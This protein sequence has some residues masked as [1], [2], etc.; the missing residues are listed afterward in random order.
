MHLSKQL[1]DWQVQVLLVGL[2]NKDKP[3]YSGHNVLLCNPP[4]PPHWNI[5]GG[6]IRVNS[7][8]LG[9][10]GIF[11]PFVSGRFSEKTQERSFFFVKAS[12]YQYLRYG[13]GGV[14]VMGNEYR[15]PLILWEWGGG[16]VCNVD[17]NKGLHVWVSR[18]F[19]VGLGNKDTPPYLGHNVLLCNPTPTRM[20]KGAACMLIP[21]FLRK[22]LFWSFLSGRF[23]EKTRERGLLQ[24]L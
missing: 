12:G 1:G 15:Y 3:P 10:R 24:L 13:G 6:R 2:C 4:P 16:G 19:L 21:I 17:L 8:F 14:Q 9:K 23:S 20:Y 7:H 5:H 11:W 22:G 18:S